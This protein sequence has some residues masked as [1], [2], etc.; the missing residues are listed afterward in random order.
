MKPEPKEPQP[1]KT[2]RK[3][4]MH[5]LQA[6]GEQLVALA[7]E[8]LAELALPERLADAIVEAKRIAGFEA[9]R[10][11]MQFIGRL[12]RDIDA[13]PIAERIAGLASAARA[14]NARHREAEE[15]RERLLADEGAVTELARAHAGL[16]TQQLRV[17]IRNTRKER[18][19]GRPPHAARAL[20]R[21]LRSVL[22][23]SD[24]SS[25][26]ASPAE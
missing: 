20:Y 19:Q 8:Q 3:K 6:L 10:R 14:A 4:E 11:Q 5:A 17:L 15:W 25:P 22:S 12:M 26:P 23:Q 9:R 24:P 16:D 2:Q 1:S 21:M 7:P 13:A 18:A